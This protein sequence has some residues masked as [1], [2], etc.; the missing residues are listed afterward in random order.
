MKKILILVCAI[1][2]SST[3][4]AQYF[5]QNGMSYRVISG[6]SNVETT[7][8][9]DKS[10]SHFEIPETVSYNGNTYTI[11]TIGAGSFQ[12]CAN[13]TS[14]T[15]PN[16]I[17]TIE[18]A[19]F[20]SCSS[21]QNITLP[22]NITSIGNFAFLNCNSLTSITLP[23]S[24]TSIGNNAFQNC[25]SLTSITLPNNITSIGNNT[26]YGCTAL[27]SITLPNSI[28]SIGNYT[29]LGCTALTSVTCLGET[30][31]TLG[32][33]VFLNIN[34]N[35]TL[36]I[37]EGSEFSYIENGW[38]NYF[39]ITITSATY[40][41]L[42]YKLNNQDNTAI[43]TG[44]AQGHQE[45]TTITIPATITINENTYTVTAIKDNAFF[46]SLPPN[47][48]QTLTSVIF[49][50]NSNVTSIGE[51]AFSFCTNLSSINI[52]NSVTSIGEATFYF[53]SNL[54]SVTCLGETAPVLGGSYVFS[55]TPDSKTLTIPF[56]SEYDYFISSYT[57][58]VVNH[59]ISQ[60]ETKFLNNPFAITEE[61]KIINDGVLVI[62]QGGELINE[63]E[64][65]LGGIIEVETPVLP[66][67]SWSFIG[68][69][70]SG[71]KL[72][73]IIPGERDIAISMFNYD[74]ARWS[75]QFDAEN[76]WG[77]METEVGI[78]EGFFAW[79][80]ADEAPTAFTTYGNGAY[81]PNAHSYFDSC[82]YDFS[83]TVA[84][85]INKDTLN[86]TK[87]LIYN[88]GYW[89]PLAN[90]YTFKLDIEKFLQHNPSIQGE[91]I[92]KLTQDTNNA[93]VWQTLSSGEILLTEGFFVNLSDDD[94]DTLTKLQ[95]GYVRFNL[96]QRFI[97]SYKSSPRSFIKLVMKEGDNESKLLF[98]HNEKAQQDYD[99]F[100]ANKLFSPSNVTEHYFVNNDKAL[101]KEEVN[102][103][104]YTAK[105]NVR[106]YDKKEVCFTV[107]D[108][109]ED[110]AVY[111]I[112]NGYE[113]KM[114]NNQE[115][116]TYVL[117]G[118][119]E[120][121]FQLLV[122]KQHRL[123]TIKSEQISITNNNREVKVA[124]QVENLTIEIYN[125]L[126]QKVFTT[127]DYN[128]ILNAIPAGAY[129]VKAFYNRISQTQKIV[130]E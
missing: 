125:S 79:S 28:T 42:N 48:N 117:E 71:Y 77:S 110:V 10:I 85:N 56:G 31:P 18:D 49:E 98:A 82:L 21:L 89:L 22:S 101:V 58:E 61:N 34:P 32:D 122:K 81:S 113:T 65:N 38:D 29:F 94:N 104:P 41:G 103:L 90:P 45:D 17:T 60:G 108:I 102:S 24:I 84:Y 43:V 111:L 70:F 83:T 88:S 66:N 130:I 44:F 23:N 87:D 35:H 30:A 68:A 8:V 50:E 15:L 99:I 47:N 72:E 33:A 116:R 119:N 62:E 63:T 121:R 53:C 2:F 107:E 64:E 93:P 20:L 1:L 40:N 91:V 120:N 3:L 109:P 97:N 128:F 57:W 51:N 123:E 14:V 86:V 129:T 13:L 124:S 106:S 5:Q 7:G 25:T 37:P 114:N 11:T 96:D 78:G 55:S 105:L 73:A 100:D 80:F 75:N 118:E 54:S 9:S 4:F 95:D 39:T 52:P 76:Q 36:S 6:S 12:N 115:Y 46:K 16:S 59:K 27:T 26:F 127:K 126:G 92:Y 74:S 19:A 67:N 112:D 69:P